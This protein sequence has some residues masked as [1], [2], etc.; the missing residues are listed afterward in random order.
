MK[1]LKYLIGL[2]I[3]IAIAL[4]LIFLL[5][6]PAPRTNK[7]EE[8]IIIPKGATL[9]SV[10]DSLAHYDILRSKL[11]FKLAARLL[12]AS[13]NIQPG[14]YRIAYGLTNTEIVSRLTG[15]AYAI[16]FEVTFPEGSHLRRVASIAKQKL[17]IDSVLFMKL[18]KD[19]AFIHS[20]GIPRAARTAEGYLFPETYRFYVS[21]SPQD[22]IKKMAEEWKAKISDSLLL[23]A[24]KMGF[25]VHEFMTF[26]SIVEA[27]AERADE[28]DT[29]AG[30]YWNRL[31]L[32]MKLDA[33]PTVQ[34]G[35][36]LNRPVNADELLTPNSYNTYLNE[37]LPPGPINNPGKA[38]IIAALHPAHHDKLYFVARRDGSGGHY[39]SKTMKEQEK[40]IRMSNRNEYGK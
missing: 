4:W 2:V 11:T 20:L 37:G 29:I 15:T 31:K 1:K 33:D 9:S 32:G 39:F 19:T 38:S 30:V 21:V 18:V 23:E 7:T 36:G 26:A 8:I 13:T 34:Y 14:S 28:R 6:N 24:K 17:G 10:A 27:E 25:S 22:L 35:L 5:K 12:G 16:I 3:L 40:A